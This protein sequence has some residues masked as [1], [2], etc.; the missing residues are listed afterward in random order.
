[1]K[2]IITTVFVLAISFVTALPYPDTD[3]IDAAGA[4][5]EGVRDVHQCF[6]FITY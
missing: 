4:I 1:M 5:Y 3:G 2:L 6:A